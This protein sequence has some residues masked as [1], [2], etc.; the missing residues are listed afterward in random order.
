MV[1]S[2]ARVCLQRDS[3][4]HREGTPVPL[5]G[6]LHFPTGFAFAGPGATTLLTP[7]LSDGRFPLAKSHRQTFRAAYHGTTD[8]LGTPNERCR[9]FLGDG[10]VQLR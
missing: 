9:A 2:L 1:L 5:K 10:N 8:K 4:V 3:G 6:S 7:D